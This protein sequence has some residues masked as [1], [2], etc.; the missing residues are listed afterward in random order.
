MDIIGWFIFVF[1]LMIGSFL[2]VL[3]LRM[4]E[5]KTIVFE[6]S[7]C[8]KCKKTIAWYDLVPFLSFVLLKARCRNCN[9]KIS[10][11]YPLVEV[12]TALLFTFLYL[13]KGFGYEL[14][15]YAVVFSL[16]VVL[17]VY[18]LKTETVPDY[19]V[20]PALGL[21][22]VGGML[23][24]H[25][26][27]SSLLLGGLVGALPLATL[28]IVSKEKWMGAG[29]IA[30]GAILGLLCGFE[31]SIV[32]MFM[33]FVLGS[34]VGLIYLYITDKKVTRKGLKKSLPF[35]PFLI[36]GTLI[37]VTYGETIVRW[38]LNIL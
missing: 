21:A 7:H 6:R 11:Q 37:G 35:A 9:E 19:F 27:L 5:L 2:N 33:A 8:P 25:F 31:A 28:V 34:V 3:I 22:L 24:G 18:D 13:N 20:W 17:F 12:G 26:S 36:L 4:D 14:L 15:F 30:I 29:D 32:G 10:W 38:Y 23:A 16:L 1:G